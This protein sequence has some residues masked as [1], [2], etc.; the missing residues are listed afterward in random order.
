MHDQEV[1]KKFP[2]L[3]IAVGAIRK[4]KAEIRKCRVK[5]TIGKGSAA[6]EYGLFFWYSRAEL[7]K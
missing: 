2:K 7:K 5:I 1:G 3:K 6:D 4:I